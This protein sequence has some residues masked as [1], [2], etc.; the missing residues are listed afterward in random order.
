MPIFYTS[1]MNSFQRKYKIKFDGKGMKVLTG[2]HVAYVDF[3]SD[4]LTV[5]SR[6]IGKLV[7]ACHIA[8]INFCP[9]ATA[10]MNHIYCIHCK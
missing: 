7:L 9:L 8:K 5:G 1:C 3:P 10:N 6:I 2:K 4:L